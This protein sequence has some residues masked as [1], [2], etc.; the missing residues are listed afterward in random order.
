MVAEDVTQQDLVISKLLRQDI[1]QYKSLFPHVS[2]AIQLSSTYRRYPSKGDTIN[3]IYT[4]T[5]HKNPPCRIE[6]L[7]TAQQGDDNNKSKTL[8]YD[9]EKYRKKI[10][11]AV[12][13]VLGTFGFDRTVYGDSKKR[14]G[15]W[16]QELIQ[17]R[18]RDIQIELT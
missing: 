13:T 9:N 18:R 4:N 1:E 16:W 10:L 5:Q 17:E 2:A 8:N 3:Y 12:E 11:D 14:K 6:A 7:H 15:K